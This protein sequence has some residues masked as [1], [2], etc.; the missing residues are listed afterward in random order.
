M[1]APTMCS[2]AQEYRPPRFRLVG[3]N[4]P[5]EDFLDWTRGLGV[6]GVA[7]QLIQYPNFQSFDTSKRTVSMFH[8]APGANDFQKMP[9][10]KVVKFV[11]GNAFKNFKCQCSHCGEGKGNFFELNLYVPEADAS[12][13]A[14][15]HHTTTT[16]GVMFQRSTADDHGSVPTK[17]EHWLFPQGPPGK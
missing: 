10:G 13:W 2:A 5:F 12:R 4:R 1:A 11:M 7:I 15:A 8:H 3:D 14:S 16:H 17:G 6:I 9:E